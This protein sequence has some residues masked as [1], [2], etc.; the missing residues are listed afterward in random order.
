MWGLLLLSTCCIGGLFREFAACMARTVFSGDGWGRFIEE[1][2]VL[3]GSSLARVGCYTY[4]EGLRAFG[5]R[6]SAYVGILWNGFWE[7]VLFSGLWFD[8]LPRD[9]GCG[10]VQMWVLGGF[11]WC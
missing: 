11:D 9:I 10:G 1:G 5:F 3:S 8:V 7:G 6:M 2:C 4:F